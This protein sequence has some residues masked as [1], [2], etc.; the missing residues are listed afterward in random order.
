MQRVTSASV[1]TSGETVGEISKG[2]LILL[3]VSGADKGHDASSLAEKLL[4]LRVMSD[5]GGKMNLDIR[6]SKGEILVV[7][8]FTLYADTSKGNR[9]SFVE[10]AEGKKANQLYNLFI[11][12][13]R[14][15]GQ[16]VETGKFGS[17][18][19]IAAVLDGPATIVLET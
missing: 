9:P 7:S 13:I 12:E 18:M 14:K 3:G 15:T 4:K 5:E 17:Y 11:E 19:E 1:K 10:A 8:Q 16:K 6:D 2:Y